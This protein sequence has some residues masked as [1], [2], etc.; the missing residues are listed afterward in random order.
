VKTIVTAAFVMCWALVVGCGGKKS[1][2]TMPASSGAP[3]A[4]PTTM[5]N[6]P[7][8]EID[9][10][11]KEIDDALANAGIATLTPAACEATHS[12]TAEPYGVPPR[13]EDPT[14][15]AP[16]TDTCTQS[17]TL[18]DSVCSSAEKICNLARTLP[19]DDYANEKCQSA[20][21][22]CKRTRERCCGCS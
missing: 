13:I 20:N 5:P 7:R 8:N 11:A 9:A 3:E 21:D 1:P 15:K 14:C 4:S 19:G 18:S 17:C 6:D 10:L 16:T 12:C 22:S 2:A